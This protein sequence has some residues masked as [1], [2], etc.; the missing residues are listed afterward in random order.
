MRLGRRV[1]MRV[2]PF[3]VA[4]LALTGGAFAQDKYGTVRTVE[5][6]EIW[7]A[8]GMTVE[9]VQFTPD[10]TR[11]RFTARGKDSVLRGSVLPDGTGFE[12]DPVDAA[13]ADADGAVPA[14][15]FR[16]EKCAAAS[17]D[18]KLIACTRDLLTVL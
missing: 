5:S 11:I 9:H 15:G 1:A 13:P 2:L 14:V 4:S 7:K 6:K 8:D 10:G 18:G 12:T 16:D 17:P 3:T